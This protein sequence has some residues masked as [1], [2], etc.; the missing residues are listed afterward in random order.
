MAEKVCKGGEEPWESRCILHDCG[1]TE[2][3]DCSWVQ[4][5]MVSSRRNKMSDK[6]S[7][8]KDLF[9]LP[10]SQGSSSEVTGAIA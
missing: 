7:L 6:D 4:G 5:G 1:Q 8:R 2:R 9:G 3:T 10:V